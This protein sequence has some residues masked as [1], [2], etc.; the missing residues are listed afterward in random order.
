MRWATGGII[1]SVALHVGAAAGLWRIPRNIHQGATSITMADGK[2]PK[3]KKDDPRKEEA[4]KDE[5]PKPITAPEAPV[6]R[7]AAPKPSPAQN[8][9]P[10]PLAAVAAPVAQAP[11][12]AALPDLGLSFGNAGGP[13]GMAIAAAAP[14]TATD[15]GSR[16]KTAEA[17]KG[18]LPK[19][20]NDDD[21]VEALVKPRALTQEQG[22]YTPEAQSA[23][24]EGRVRLRIQV[25]TAGKVVSVSVSQGLGHGL[26]ESAIAAARR[27]KLSA[28]TRCG[29]PVEGTFLMAMSFRLPE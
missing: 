8:T 3:P 13:G 19:P 12:L 29:V 23:G 21:C 16:P 15:T 5:P 9:P 28:A 6:K 10:P 4:K 1:L 17:P 18:V 11:S 22:A 20:K 27:M 2:K 24:I 26:D 14:G 25:D 7:T